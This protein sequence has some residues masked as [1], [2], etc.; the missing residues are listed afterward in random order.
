[1]VN[2]TSPLSFGLF[3]SG[4]LNLEVAVKDLVARRGLRDGAEVMLSGD[5]AGGFGTFLN[6]DWLADTLPWALVK[7]APV[8]GYV[9]ISV[10]VLAVLTVLAAASFPVGM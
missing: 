2:R 9:G 10:F 1:M 4:H 7:G 6:V 3:F 8:A 5:S